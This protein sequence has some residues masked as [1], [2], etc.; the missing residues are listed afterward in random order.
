MTDTP[1]CYNCL[2][3][4]PATLSLSNEELLQLGQNCM[5]TSM[6]AGETIF[7]QGVFSMGVVYIKHGIVKLHIDGPHKEQIIKIVKGPAYIGIPTGIE[8][9]YYRYTATSV[10]NTEACFINIEAFKKFILNNG[11]FAYEIIV[12]LCRDELNLL[13]IRI[14]NTQKNIRGR[15]ADALLFFKH[16]IYESSSYSL[17]VTRSEFG[18]FVDATRESVSRILTEFHTEKIIK[19]SGKKVDI[20]NE[21]LLRLISKTG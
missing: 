8:E 14:S 19:L 9:K 3:K 4:S 12:Q 5:A 2:F 21:K 18:N 1:A 17:P 10:E 16:E 20:V 6:N 15:I 7:K 13:R 11:L